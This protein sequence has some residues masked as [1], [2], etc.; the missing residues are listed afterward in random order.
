MSFGFK[1]ILGTVFAYYAL[2]AAFNYGGI[3]QSQAEPS[4][5]E[6]TL[7]GGIKASGALHMD[8]HGGMVLVKEDGHELHLQETLAI[9]YLATA[10][11]DRQSWPFRVL[12][13]VLA[14]V[15]VYL[16]WLYSILRSGAAIRRIRLAA[17]NS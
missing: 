2:S 5:V 3:W 12:A 16:F 11:T 14:V 10:K 6:V 13:P 7:Q 17:K 15:F 9:T 1:W 8:W 4:L